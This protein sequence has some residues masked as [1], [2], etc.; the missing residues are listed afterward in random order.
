MPWLLATR[1]SSQPEAL[2]AYRRRLWIEEMLG[3]VKE[4]GF[5]GFTWKIHASDAS[6]VFL[7]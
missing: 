3:D 6:C 7:S 4:H 1:F 2:R 5:H